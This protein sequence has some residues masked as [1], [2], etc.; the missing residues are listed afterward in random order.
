MIESK[1]LAQVTPEESYGKPSH[2][3]GLWMAVN[4]EFAT[5]TTGAIATGVFGLSVWDAVLAILSANVIGC[6]LLGLFSTYGVDFGMPMMIICERWFGRFGNRVLSLLT[7]LNGFSWFAINTVI[8]AYFIQHAVGIS[9]VAGIASLT[10]VQVLIAIIG[11]DF[12]IKAEK[13]FFWYLG[14]VFALLTIMTLAHIDRLPAANPGKLAMV[15]GRSGAF[16]LTVSVMLSWLGGW[17]LFSGDYSRYLR[18]QADR[19]AV[20]KQVFWN[21]CMGCF[22]SSTWLEILG[23]ILGGTI[24]LKTPADLFTPWIAPWLR[25]PLII[26]IVVGT[27]SPNVLNIYSAGLSALAAGV[28]LK[29][30]Q[31]ALLTGGIGLLIALMTYRNFY[32]DYELLLFFLGYLIFPR[33]PVMAIGHARP[34]VARLA[35]IEVGTAGFLAWFAGLL[36]SVPFWNQPPVFVGWFASRFPR[37]GDISF[38]VGAAVAALVYLG[39]TAAKP[40]PASAA[41]AR[42]ASG[43]AHG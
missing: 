18:Y 6:V 2:L 39:M 20:K 12:I 31:A 38:F 35:R 15:G 13:A 34:R 27:I 16:L 37:F 9:L 26:A 8:G 19:A 4:V 10:A 42:A 30:W 14:A 36:C 32:Q 5:I 33:F 24:A 7:F 21:A 41:D 43:L 1:G 17:I 25:A 23:A 3:F 29:Q 28:R 11:H 40:R 22:V